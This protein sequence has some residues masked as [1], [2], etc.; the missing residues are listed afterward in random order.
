M[1]PSKNL[2]EC[3]TR[4]EERLS[5]WKKMNFSRRLWAKDPT[6]WASPQTPGITDRLGWLNL[7]EL[8]FDKIPEMEAFAEDVKAEGFTHIILLGMGGSSLAPEVFQ[9][10][11]GNRRGFPELTVLDT[12]HPVAVD[13]L[14]KK[15]DLSQSLFLVSSKSGTTVEPLSFF[16]YFWSKVGR[17]TNTPGRHF[18]AITDPGTSLER[19]A[20][21]RSFRRIFLAYPEVGGRYSALTEFGLVPAALIG[22]DVLQLLASA[23]EAAKNN[24]FNVPENEASGIVLGAAL[25]ETAKHRDK[26]TIFTSP[27]LASF[28]DW[29]EQLIAESTGKEGKGIVPVANESLVPPGDYGKDRLFVSFIL[30]NDQAAEIEARMKTLEKAGHPTIQ[31]TLKDKVSLGQ[32]IFHWEI[33]VAAAGAILGINPFNQ[34]DV[35]LAKELARQAMAER[36]ENGFKAANIPNAI[37]AADARKLSPALESWIAQAQPGDYIALQAYLPPTE[38]ITQALQ[39]LR[40]DLLKRTKVATTLGYGPRFLHSTGQ[41]HKGGPNEALILQLVDEPALD[42]EV[43]ET[44]YSFNTLIQAQSLGDYQALKQRGRRVLRLNL[45]HDPLGGLERIRDLIR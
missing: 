22:M 40:L 38:K 6:L 33:A 18:V 15:L 45:K 43:P 31:I 10:T 29:L 30:L 1:N 14:E 26:L 2:Q 24:A 39:N 35:D 16:R 17:N 7:P 34:P 20:R 36:K 19:L 9:K 28:P 4:V 37:S 41:L 27:S 5:S 25:G 8:M 32:E 23:R 12:T 44:D 13:S 42:L 11:F 21:E 3:E